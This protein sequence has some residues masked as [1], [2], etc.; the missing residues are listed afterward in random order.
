MPVRYLFLTLFCYLLVGYATAQTRLSGRVT[1]ERGRALPGANVFIRG[2]YDGANTD[3]TGTFR[4]QTSKQDS[5]LLVVSYMGYEPYSK[6]LILSQKELMVQV[7]LAELP[8]ELNTVVITAGAF[9]ASDEKRMTHLKAMDIVTTAGAAADITAAVSFMP[10][11]QRVG[12]QAGLFVRGG[13]ALEAK[14]VIDG[15]VVQN[16]FFSAL[17]DVQNRGRFNPFQ[18]KGTSF[19]TGGYSAQYGQALSGVLLLNTTDLGRNDGFAL[20]LNMAGANLDYSW[21]SERASVSGSLNYTNLTPFFKLIRQNVAWLTVPQGL[22]GSLTYRLKPTQTGLLKLYGMYT[23]NRLGMAFRDP[24]QAT[25][26]NPTGLAPLQLANNNAFATGT[27]T[28]SWDEG[29]WLLNTG[30]SISHDTDAQTISEVD[31]GRSNSRAQVRTTLT[32]L[33]PGNNTLLV[34]AEAHTLKLNTGV[35][36]RTY[37]L[38][39][40]Y[41][42][43]FA[44]TQHYVTRQLAVQVGIRAEYTSILDRFNVAPRFSAAYKTGTYSQI[45][46]AAGQFYQT[47]DHTYLYRNPALGYERADHLIAQYQLMRNKRTVRV[48]AFYKNYAQLVL[49]RTAAAPGT[50]PPFDANPYRFPTGSTTNAGHGYAQGFDVFWRDQTS[51]KGLDYWITYSYLDTRR[52]F[53]NYLTLATPTFASAHNL[54]LITKRY[55]QKLRTTLSLTYAYTSGRPY[56]NPNV[57]DRTRPEA[58]FL[59]DR[60]PA[61]HNLSWQANYLTSLRGNFVILYAAV[62]NVLNTQNV[63][64]YRFSPDG[65]ERYA[66]GPAAYRTLFVGGIIMLSKKAKI[67]A[68]ER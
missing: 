34:G 16:P 64:S 50:L 61:V 3:S 57:A 31:V 10:G 6:L 4:F 14:V 51:V 49:E 1:D 47:P 25:A 35:L 12:E 21:A 59:T 28:D 38:R 55:V 33:L 41:T 54:S 32:R 68:E 44:E 67:K 30:F 9:E 18:F 43:L 48:E 23:H 7:R 66:I 29:R 37:T 63:F 46:I 11:A 58:D 27:Y 24:A 13:S 65:K 60:T 26:T 5:A 17:P 19:S 39:D 22:G 62:D 8:S 45:S 15:M 42:A 52:L 36:G 40:T 56:Y 2:S 53:R 20:G